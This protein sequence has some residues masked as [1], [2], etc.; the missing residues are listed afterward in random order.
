MGEKQSSDVR[1]LNI[2]QKLSAIMGDIG[3]VEKG[4]K[5]TEQNY[6]F[7]EYAAVAGK[8]RALFSEY[9][10][11]IVPRMPKA[12][13]HVREEITTKYG[14]KGVAILIDFTFEI[15][16]ADKPDDKFE[17]TWTGEA[18]DYGDKGTNKAAT[19][20]LKYYLMRQFNI[21]EKGEDNDEHSIDRGS[22]ETAPAKP[23]TKKVT[24]ISKA[25]LQAIQKGLADKG[26]E[27]D[28]IDDTIKRLAKVE[29]LSK[30]NVASGKAI[31]EKVTKANSQALR[32]FV[33]GGDPNEE[34]NSMPDDPN[35]EGTQDH[36]N[37]TSP[38]EPSQDE[39]EA[40]AE[41]P[42]A[43]PEPVVD[44]EFKA[45]AW[46]MYES[47][48]IKSQYK[49]R[50]LK[51]VTG[52]ISKN[53]IKTDEKWRALMD[54]AGAVLSGDEEIPADQRTDAGEQEKIV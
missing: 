19:S 54:R 8:L 18:A 23:I 40:A 42:A 53:S 4:G 14:S 10:V 2:Y 51:D 47:L 45:T 49:L 13:E 3:V 30:I 27:A 33:Y 22:T 37:I 35:N 38:N 48:P 43:D 15:I 29:D 12:S 26:I 46:E 28:D 34:D 5:N 52:A 21:S 25:T 36:P 24:Y 1:S 11:L 39:I 31:L 7:I 32:E 6:A 20:A 50:W 41:E 44:D 17:V 16:N 9:G